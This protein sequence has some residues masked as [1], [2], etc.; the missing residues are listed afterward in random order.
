[1]E[2]VNINADKNNDKRS[3]GEKI[4]YMLPFLWHEQTVQNNVK[5]TGKQR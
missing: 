5:T 1:M 3:T 2:A 4:K